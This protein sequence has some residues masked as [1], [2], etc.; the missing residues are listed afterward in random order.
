MELSWSGH[1]RFT[2]IVGA[3]WTFHWGRCFCQKRQIFT[4]LYLFECLRPCL[5]RTHVLQKIGITAVLNTAEG[6]WSEWGFVDLSPSHYQG[7]GIHY[8]VTPLLLLLISVDF[9]ED[10]LTRVSAYGTHREPPLSRTL[11]LRQIT[12]TLYCQRQE[13]R[14][15]IEMRRG[16]T[17]DWWA[18][19]NLRI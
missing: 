16:L 18:I 10:I 12:W 11:D 4:G 7:S 17:G 8:Q 14:S 6:P 13:E 5:K 15:G 2:W 3:P 19:E 1:S 9:L